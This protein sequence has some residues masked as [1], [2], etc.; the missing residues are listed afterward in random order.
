MSRLGVVTRFADGVG[1]LVAKTGGGAVSFERHVC[2]GEP[3]QGSLVR[4]DLAPRKRRGGFIACKVQVLDLNRSGAVAEE[5]N[6]ASAPT[7]S[8]EETNA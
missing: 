6:S 2:D 7:S 3:R 8:M 4:F 1:Q 5:V